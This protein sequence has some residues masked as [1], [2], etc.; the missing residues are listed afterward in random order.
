MERFQPILLRFH[1]N[2]IE[3]KKNLPWNSSVEVIWA[4][5][6]LNQ[7]SIKVTRTSSSFSVKLLSS[8][9]ASR[10]TESQITGWLSL[11]WTAGGHL[12][13]NTYSSRAT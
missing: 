1:E 11:A 8:L 12:V 9:L 6:C 4:N 5:R 3:T 13:K 10:S 7:G 2:V